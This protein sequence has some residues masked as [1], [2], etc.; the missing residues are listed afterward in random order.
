[1]NTV[2]TP[3]AENRQK[4]I[5]DWLLILTGLCLIIFAG[6]ILVGWWAW[7]EFGPTATSAPQSLITLADPVQT[8]VVPAQIPPIVWE[9]AGYVWEITPRAIYRVNGRILGHKAYHM[10]WQS[11]A[12]PLD[13]ALGWGEM[14]D[15]AV[16]EWISWR[17]AN[18]WYYYRWSHEAPFTGAYIG[19]HSANIHIIPATENLLQ[20][21]LRLDTNDVILLE[22][23]LV[24]L[25][26]T[27]GAKRWI[28]ATSLSRTDTGNGACEIMYVERLLWNGQ[29]YR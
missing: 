10:D 3:S 11:P 6:S 5:V 14:A 25:A 16:D 23:K 13:L 8:A 27:G 2:V 22:G 26:A 1:M 20:I 15:P 17:Q 19:Q 24:D 4:A 18:R 7:N 12:V 9:K 28:N 21:M 29:E